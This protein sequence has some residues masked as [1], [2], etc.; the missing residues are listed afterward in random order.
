MLGYGPISVMN[1]VLKSMAPL[2][3]HSKYT[4]PSLKPLSNLTQTHSNI[5]QTSLS[6][7][8]SVLITLLTGLLRHGT[9]RELN[10][11]PLQ[12]L[13]LQLLLL[14][15]QVIWKERRRHIQQSSIINLS[16]ITHRTSRKQ[17]GQMKHRGDW[18]G[19]SSSTAD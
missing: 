9:H 6:S 14:F 19:Y 16:I 7:S 10:L 13:L 2:N 5:T 18:V 15:S 8:L 3:P 1:T 12:L 11:F 4:Q 17:A